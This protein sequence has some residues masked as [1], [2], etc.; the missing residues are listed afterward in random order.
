[1]IFLLLTAC[2]VTEGP[3]ERLYTELCD[4][5]TMDDY[6]QTYCT[7][8]EEGTLTPGDFPD[9]Y[10]ISA[11]EAAYTCDQQRYSLKYPDPWTESY[12][13]VEVRLIKDYPKLVCDDLGFSNGGDD[14][15]STY[16][17]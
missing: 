15:G 14:T 8:L 1:M 5:C 10:D 2:G 3:C 9:G 16:G 17:Y 12:C 11:D 7:C 4:A 6:D 13:Q